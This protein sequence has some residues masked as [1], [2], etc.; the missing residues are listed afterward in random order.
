MS[1]E[2][3]YRIR[4]TDFQHRSLSEFLFPGDGLEAVCIVL[5]GQRSNDSDVILAVHEIHQVHYDL[6]DRESDRITWPVKEVVPSIISA[7]NRNLAI[8]KIHSH[9]GGYSGFSELDDVSDLQLFTSLESWTSEDT[10]N[11]S[12]IMLPDGSMIGRV[13]HSKEIRRVNRFAIVGKR[14]SFFGLEDRSSHEN[15]IRNI[16]ALGVRTVN[17]FKNLKIG[18]VGC[19]GTGSWVCELLG[20]YGPKEMVLVDP[21][22]VEKL[23]LNRIV[24]ATLND[25]EQRI[26]KVLV[27]KRS[28]EAMGFGT[29]V[30]AMNDHLLD[31]EV[32]KELASCDV[33]FGCMDSHDGRDILNRISTFYVIPYWDVG[34]SLIA[35]D[36]GGLSN[37]S[38]RV[39]YLIPGE[40]TLLSRGHID[41]QKVN[42]QSMKRLDPELYESRVAEGY[43]ANAEV[44]SPAVSSVNSLYSALAI[45]DFIA[46]LH[47]YRR[48]DDFNE[49]GI[50]L[51]NTYM[52]TRRHVE[53]CTRL[54]VRL[55]RGDCRPLLDLPQL[56]R[57]LVI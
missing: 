3:T 19:S 6:C 32:V 56:S 38:G 24:N 33:L 21:E 10:P 31:E 5:C 41:S 43:I 16:Q 45:N 37:V 51:V 53:K 8:L 18:V 46:R 34:V 48:D 15:D 39:D 52:Q 55:G 7:M 44:A 42:A 40:S 23:N 49:V 27:Q 50:C 28:I 4:M 22:P 54:S 1:A 35:D 57:S 13:F 47:G 2:N 36:I 9:P 30:K 17:I 26:P 25:A 20:R 11:G 12:L 29:V 14:L